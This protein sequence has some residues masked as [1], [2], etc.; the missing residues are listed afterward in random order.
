MN[1]MQLLFY[2][3]PISAFLLLVVM[4]FQASI[5][6]ILETFRVLNTFQWFIF[7]VSGLSAFLV[8]LTTFWILKNTSGE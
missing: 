5:G 2:Q 3:A 7:I 6:E 4:P 1:S 8:N